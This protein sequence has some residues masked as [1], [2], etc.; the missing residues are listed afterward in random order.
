LETIEIRN[1]GMLLSCV[2]ISGDGSAYMGVFT[3][4]FSAVKI[5]G[6]AEFLAKYRVQ[7]SSSSQHG[8]PENNLS[9]A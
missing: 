1:L 5:V 4:A 3:L 7:E 9:L 6:L 8:W 2:S